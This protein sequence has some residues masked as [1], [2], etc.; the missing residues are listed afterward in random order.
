VP[1]AWVDTLAALGFPA[2]GDPFSAEFL[3]GISTPVSI[4]S[5]NLTRFGH[6]HGMNV[7]SGQLQ[8]RLLAFFFPI[9]TD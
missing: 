2:S 9:L 4:P 6:F 8:L 7:A 1:A 3:A 5:L